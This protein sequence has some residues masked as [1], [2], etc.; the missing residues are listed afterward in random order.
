MEDLL[1]SRHGM[2]AWERRELVGDRSTRV[3][4][5]IHNEGG[6]A[7]R[8]GL[9]IVDGEFNERSSQVRGAELVK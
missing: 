4:P 1:Q 7:S 2:G 3:C 5:S 6:F 8:G 9:R